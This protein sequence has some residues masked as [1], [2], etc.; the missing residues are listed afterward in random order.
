MGV[1]KA[2][3][4]TLLSATE[5]R[6]S[7][8]EIVLDG[9]QDESAT[10]RRGELAS[11]RRDLNS[12]RKRMHRPASVLELLIWVAS[13]G[14]ATLLVWASVRPNVVV[15]FSTGLALILI[16]V[17]TA[18]AATIAIWVMAAHELR[19]INAKLK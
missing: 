5:G 7:R 15:S 11:V 16:P 6:L 3:L 18:A 14:S 4:S 10:A 12:A 1:F 17:A 2:P 13:L 8:E 19:D 9:R